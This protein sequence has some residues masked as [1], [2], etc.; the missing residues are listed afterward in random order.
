MCDLSGHLYKISEWKAKTKLFFVVVIINNVVLLLL[1]GLLCVSAFV[2]LSGENVTEE[3]IQVDKDDINVSVMLCFFVIFQVWHCFY[4]LFYDN[5]YE[6]YATMGTKFLST[7]YAIYRVLFERDDWP[8][9]MVYDIIFLTCVLLFQ[10]IYLLFIPSLHRDYS[11]RLYKKVGV[12]N[13]KRRIHKNYLIFMTL[14]KFDFMFFFINAIISG[15]G[16]FNFETDYEYIFDLIAIIVSILTLG[17]GWY[18]FKNGKLGGTLVFFFLSLIGPVYVGYNI[19]LSFTP[20]GFQQANYFFFITAVFAVVLRI[21]VYIFAYIVLKNF[22]S[23]LEYV[24]P[25]NELVGSDELEP[26]S[27]DFSFESSVLLSI[28]FS[29]RKDQDGYQYAIEDVFRQTTKKKNRKI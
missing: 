2:H 18:A 15:K 6:L 24:D 19:Y 17:V 26:Q 4:G 10:I 25:R 29:Y 21:F 7:A 14:L 28:C 27:Y 11:W 9:E 3:R 22:D 1:S 13:E 23:R 12:D 16:I 20:T 8:E 5:L